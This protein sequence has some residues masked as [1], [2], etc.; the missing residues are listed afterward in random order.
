MKTNIFE[1]GEK[2]KLSD[3]LLDQ[4]SNPQDLNALIK[5]LQQKG[6]EKFLEAEMDEHLGYKKH[7]RNKS[8]NARN[9]KTSKKIKSKSGEL[10]IS[11]PRDRDASFEPIAVPKRKSYIDGLENIVISMYAKGI[12]NADIAE[13]IE[14]LYEFKLST[15]AISR[16]TDKINDEIKIWQNRP[17]Q[18]LYCVVWMDA[19][20][21]PIRSNGQVINKSIYIAIGLNIQGRKEVLGIWLAD[22]ESAS[23]WMNVLSELKQRGV[24]DILI[25]ATDNLTGF[26]KSISSIFPKAK[27]QICVIHQIR[28][29][30]RYVVWKDKK[31]FSKDLKAIYGAVSIQAAEQALEALDKKW[32]A[33]YKYAVD[34]WKRNWNELTVFFDFPAEIRKI[35]YTTNVIENLNGKIRK[36]TKNKLSFPTDQAAIKSVY[37]AINHTTKKWTMPVRNW[38][39]RDCK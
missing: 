22:S 31:E 8:K 5:E 7:E 33:K 36:Y 29:S 2:P 15:S 26:T 20:V 11:V 24:E 16:I 14:E 18:A 32:S 38:G 28:N 25:T 35:I 3:K 9:G 6:I 30:S 4:I 13:Q 23:C 21:F 37:L 34:S 10:D 19:I 17:L 39:I 12:S 1:M 27:T